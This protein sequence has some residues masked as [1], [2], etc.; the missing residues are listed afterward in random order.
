MLNPHRSDVNAVPA[1]RA[2]LARTAQLWRRRALVIR[3]ARHDF[4]A[5]YAGSALGL[6]WAV[7][8]P[9]VQFGL[10]LVVFSVF[11]GMR[12]AQSP[13][14]T[15][16]GF[17]LVSGLVPFLAFQESVALAVGYART[18]AGLIRHVRVPV[19]VHLGGAIIAVLARYAIALGLVLAAAVVAGVVKWASLPWLLVGVALLL[20]L[21][22]GCALTLYCVGAFLP[23]VVQGVGTA[24]MVLFFLTP[25]VYPESALPASVR[26]WLAVNPLIGMLD[27]FR[28][29]LV[30][31]EL[32]PVRLVTAALAALAALGVGA[33]VF[34]RREAAV[35]DLA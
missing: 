2:G 3:L 15:S 26:P 28:A 25:V 10:Y 18:S 31:A 16:F 32:V 9:A 21:V 17:Y 6:L 35:R 29:G 1:T 8:E 34:D 4:R 20:G 22:W 19:E 23:D 24:M 7:L 5:R 11:L 33:A 27:A 14:V 13:G 30:G 12:L